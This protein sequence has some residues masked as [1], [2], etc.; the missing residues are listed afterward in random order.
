MNE[1]E[2]AT[3]GQEGPASSNEPSALLVPGVIV[4]EPGTGRMTLTPEAGQLLGLEPGSDSTAALEQLPRP[5]LD[6]VHEVLAK[7]VSSTSRR[8][9]LITADRWQPAWL[10]KSR[11]PWSPA[12]PSSNC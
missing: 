1:P 7:G 11:T 4:V 9:E 3:E 8:V 6:L 12:E 2:I 5:L 10:T